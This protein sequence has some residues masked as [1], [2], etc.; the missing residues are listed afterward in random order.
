MLLGCLGLPLLRAGWSSLLAP[1]DKFVLEKK[2]HC[3]QN[4][5][6]KLH[7]GSPSWEKTKQ[8]VGTCGVAA[9]GLTAVATV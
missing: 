3:V 8:G 4:E 6:P 1:L 2:R 9:A 7:W 5:I